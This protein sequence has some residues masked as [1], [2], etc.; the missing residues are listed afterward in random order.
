L[1]QLLEKLDLEFFIALGIALVV[2]GVIIIISV[3]ILASSRSSGK[4]KA[5]VAG[6]VMIGP[7][8]IIFG[9]DKKSVKEVLLLALT[10]TIAIII[11]MILYYLLLG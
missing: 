4:G 8:P 5:K 7:I 2:V 9:T 3:A 11:A 1:E 6:I 10:V